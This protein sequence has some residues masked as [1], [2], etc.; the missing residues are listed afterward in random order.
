MN[1]F[2]FHAPSTLKEA[3][4]LLA[5]YDGGGKIMA[6]G[7][8]LTLL[9]KQSLVQPDHII[10]LHRI[11]DASGI[12]ESGGVLS[13]G[14]L[15]TQRDVEQSDVVKKSAPLLAN[16]YSRVAT[17]R[18]RNSATVGGGLAHADPAMDPPPSLLVLDA[19]VRLVS[20]SGERVV[21]ISEWYADYYETNIE[22]NEIVA[23]LQVPVQPSNLSWTYTKYLP[24]TEDDYATVSVAAL[25][26]VEGGKIA[27][28]RIGLG[29]VAPTAL[30]A[31]VVE[32]ALRGKEATPQA[33]RDAAQAVADI[34]DPTSDPRGSADYKRDMSVV[35]TRRALEQVLGVTP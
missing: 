12:S 1:D 22:E 35:F 18:I 28:V 26:R 10:S 5:K 8:A 27:D 21:P 3:A 16:A 19:S 6:G 31:T 30:R 25:G 7:T 33:L 15:A 13:I 9:L 11:K 4:E 29:A 23:E 14:G 32:D 2:E 17:V 34:V 20:A 24:R